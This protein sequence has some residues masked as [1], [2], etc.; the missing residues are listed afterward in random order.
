MM[1][2]R[3]TPDRDTGLSPA[4]VVFGRQ[5][6]DFIPVKK[7][8]YMP[9]KEWLLDAE[10]RELA[11]AKR[12]LLKREELTLGSKEL[13]PLNLGQDVS[14]QNQTGPHKLKWDKSGVVV[15]VLPFHKYHVKMDG[16]GRVSVRNRVFLRAILPYGAG[17]VRGEL[18]QPARGPPGPLGV[19]TP[20]ASPPVVLGGPKGPGRKSR[21]SWRVCSARASGPVAGLWQ[22]GVHKVSTVAL[23]RE[24]FLLEK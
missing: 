7:E 18:F 13:Q 9:R 10:Q 12:H 15:A 17:G 22:R 5:M 2:Y 23:G 20:Q 21:P 1:E 6:R 11:L 19:V 8:A 4:Q 3:N 24:E 14:V 16:T